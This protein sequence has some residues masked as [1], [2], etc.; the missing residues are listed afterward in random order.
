MILSL[1][2]VVLTNL[3]YKVSFGYF[4]PTLNV[5]FFNAYFKSYYFNPWDGIF[6]I[7]HYALGIVKIIYGRIEKNFSIIS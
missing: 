4:N 5:L 1:N 3:Y 2:T 6:I 7:F